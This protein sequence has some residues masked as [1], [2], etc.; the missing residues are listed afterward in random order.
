[1]RRTIEQQQTDETAPQS[2]ATNATRLTAAA[3]ASVRSAAARLSAYGGPD[4]V[5]IEA[6]PV[7]TPAPGQVLVRVRAAGLNALDW[8][9][10]QGYL[11][12]AMPLTL[13][14]TLG[15]ELAGEVVGIVDGVSRFAVGDRVMGPVGGF[16]AYADH[17]AVD[18]L[19]PAVGVTAGD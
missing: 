19:V 13:P 9:V 3:R 7:P 6:V 8:K 4:T 11:R 10:R 12:D 18:Q 16:G 15:V 5:R 17:V 2:G 14:A 1:M